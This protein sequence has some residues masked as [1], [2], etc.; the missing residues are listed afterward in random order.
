MTKHLV[1]HL[2]FFAK[3]IHP[4]TCPFHFKLLMLPFHTSGLHHELFFQKYMLVELCVGNYATLN[5]LVNGADG[6]F[7]D[8]K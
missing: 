2:N 5:R 8:Y 6:T 3:D 7:E 4:E 1:K